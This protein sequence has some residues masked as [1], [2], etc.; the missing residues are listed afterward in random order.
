MSV[1]CKTYHPFKFVQFSLLCLLVYEQCYNKMVYISCVCPIY[2]GFSV[3]KYC[4]LMSNSDFEGNISQT[5]NTCNVPLNK[6]CKCTSYQ[7]SLV[8]ITYFTPTGWI[9]LS[10]FSSCNY[11]TVSISD[12]IASNDCITLNNEHRRHRKP[13]VRIIGVP[14]TI[15]TPPSIYK[16]EVLL[17]EAPCSVWE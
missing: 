4:H 14:A 8:C 3:E 2:D 12:Y 13:S 16:K 1:K 11:R 5:K 6:P 7:F 9:L 15:W 17:S 10:P